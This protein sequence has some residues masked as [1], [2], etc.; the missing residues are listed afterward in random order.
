MEKHDIIEFFDKHAASWDAEM[1]RN[2]DIISLILSNGGIKQGVD[3]LDVACGTGVLIPDYLRFGAKNVVGVD[4]SPE[5]IKI[6]KQKFLGCD[7]IEFIC[8]D[9]EEVSLSKVFDCCMV[10]NAFPH[11]PNPK[12]LIAALSFHIKPGG[13]LSIAHG[14]SREKIDSHHAG[15]AS[16]VSIGLMSEDELAQIMS[17][18]FDVDI[19]ISNSQMYQVS[20]TKL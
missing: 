20:G 7:N 6:A 11:F 17:P 16:K 13:R 3:V 5:M 2:D 18:F 1:I 9:I 14:M 10:Y 19:V 12:A 4:I 8:A 15:S